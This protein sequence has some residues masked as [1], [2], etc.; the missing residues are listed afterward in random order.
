MPPKQQAA[1]PPAKGSAAIAKPMAAKPSRAGTAKG[2]A[3]AAQPAVKP[4]G[5]VEKAGIVHRKA[6]VGS[7]SISVVE[8]DI[9]L[10][11]VDAIINAANSLSFK[12]MDGGVS[13]ALRNACKPDNVNDAVKRSSSPPC[14]HRIPVVPP[15]IR[16]LLPS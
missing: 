15:P 2:P 9:T 11:R 6:Q 3:S 1:R 13:G 14:L 16:V 10:M 8:A 12:P 7:V 5:E 4:M